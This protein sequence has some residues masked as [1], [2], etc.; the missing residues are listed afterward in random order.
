MSNIKWDKTKNSNE[1]MDNA[2]NGVPHWLKGEEVDEYHAQK[3]QIKENLKRKDY[4]LTVYTSGN[5]NFPKDKTKHA[6]PDR[7]YAVCSL[8]EIPEYIEKMENAW[9]THPDLREGS[10]VNPDDIPFEEKEW[11]IYSSIR[12]EPLSEELEKSYLEGSETGF[13]E[14]WRSLRDNGGL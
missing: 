13:F 12:I 8:E 14:I 4:V 10:D 5:K 7:S 1:A 3:K 11:G 6:F 2:S 9:W